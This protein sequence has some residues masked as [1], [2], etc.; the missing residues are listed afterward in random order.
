MSKNTTDYIKGR[1]AQINPHSRF[2]K[3]FSDDNSAT[4]VATKYIPTVAKSIVNKVDSPDIPFVLSVNPYQ[5][6]EHGCVY[7]YARNTHPYWGYSAGADFEQN[8][9]VKHH[10][11]ELLRKYLNNKNYVCQPIMISGNTDC[12][13]PAEQKF[14]ITRKL[15]EICLEFNQPVNIITKN[16]LIS[17]DLDIIVSLN[18]NNLIQIVISL[19]SLDEKLRLLLEPRTAS[20]AKRMELIK[21]L[22]DLSI[23]V[24]VMMAPLIPALTE[25]EIFAM[26]KLVKETG[27][28]DLS[29]TILR[30]NGDVEP[31]FKDWLHKNFPDRAQK[32]I[33]QTA[34]CHGGVVNDSRFK[35][36][37]KGEGRYA[38]IIRSK[39]QLA[40]KKYGL[41]QGKVSSLDC[42]LFKRPGSQLVFEF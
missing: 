37:M 30:L 2:E 4:S 23:P 18:K 27:A 33:N 3:Y 14:K 6:C 24:M 42:T 5:G 15:L 32:I 16:T 8:I 39:F 9:L 40:R 12:Y 22:S 41:P 17:R 20:I 25:P 11:P 31:I 35:V 21:Q 34:E 7:C 26:A 28:T 13:Q 38:E 29:Y 10:A 1:G 19:T 36:R